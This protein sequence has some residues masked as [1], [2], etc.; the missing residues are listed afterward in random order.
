MRRWL[1]LVLL[2]AAA[3]LR[4][5]RQLAGEYE[6]VT[7]AE[8]QA[9]P[10]EGVAVRWGGTLNSARPGRERTC[11]EVVGFPLD[12][13]ARPVVSD[14]SAGR[15]LACAPGFY[16]PAVYAPG[17]EVTVV[18]ALHG[19]TKGTVGQYEYTFPRVDATEVYLWPERSREAHPG[20]WPSVGVSVGGVF[21]R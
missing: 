4:P 7:V 13:S 6:R 10:R 11:F 3:C 17:R 5:P 16:E 9:E 15:F 2:A 14:Q 21:W 12:S 8:A 20:W 19:T 1:V 18:G